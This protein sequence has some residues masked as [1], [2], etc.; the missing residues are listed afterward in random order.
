MW[1]YVLSAVGITG[2]YLAGSRKRVG[3][4]VGLGAQLLWITYAIATDQ[5]GFILASLCY[6]WVYARNWFASRVR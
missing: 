4:L 3:W 5:H 1:S 2:L 6:G